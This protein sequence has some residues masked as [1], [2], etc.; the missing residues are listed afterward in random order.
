MAFEN[1]LD[2]TIGYSDDG[3]SSWTDLAG[4][5]GE[6]TVPASEGIP[7]TRFRPNDAT[8]D[9]GMKGNGPSW[10]SVEINAA[11]DGHAD[12]QTL[13]DLVGEEIQ[14]KYTLAASG[15][16]FT[17]DAIV[18]RVDPAAATQDGGLVSVIALEILGLSASAGGA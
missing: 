13:N 6:Q 7:V 8:A 2:V 15:D 1:P 11:Y 5:Y 14:V 12:W 18:S 17:F 3:G 10:G 9:A 4:L 16:N